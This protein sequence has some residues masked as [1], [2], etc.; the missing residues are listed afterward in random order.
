MRRIDSLLARVVKLETRA[1]IAE[2][3]LVLASG[4]VIDIG[5]AG[6]ARLFREIDGKTRGVPSQQGN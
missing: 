1:E 5:G 3:P 2:Q 4:I 6:L